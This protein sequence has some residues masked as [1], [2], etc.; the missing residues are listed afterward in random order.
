MPCVASQKAMHPAC[1]DSRPSVVR[2]N[3]R[4]VPLTQTTLALTMLNPY[5]L[6]SVF[7]CCGC[8]WAKAVETS[9]RRTRNAPFR[10]HLGFAPD[11][12]RLAY[13]QIVSCREVH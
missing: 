6:V 3:V 13:P 10:L 11:L 7:E 4:P 9:N 2:A 1:H 5:R 12:F 8:H